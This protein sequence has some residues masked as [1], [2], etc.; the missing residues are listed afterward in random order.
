MPTPNEIIR[1]IELAVNEFN[2]SI[3]KSQ[4]QIFD[5]IQELTKQFTT[6]NDRIKASAENIRLISKIKQKIEKVILTPE[7]KASVKD[8]LGA[9]DTISKLQN[10]YFEENIDKYKQPAILKAIRQESIESTIESLTE[11]GLKEN[12]I[13][14]VRDILR[15]NITSGAPY[16]ELVKQL[17]ENL[18]DT[19]TG[20]GSLVKHTKQITNDALN[21]FARENIN[22]VTS[23]LGLEW[24]SYNGSIIDTSRPFCK[25]M[26]KKKFFNKSEI[27]KLLKGD[28]PEF[29]EFGGKL[30]KDT[31]LPEGMIEGTTEDNFLTNLGGFG[32]RHQ[33]VPVHESIVPDSVKKATSNA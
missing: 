2:K 22:S 11:S 6:K 4:E 1:G 24:F 16:S 28:F 23:D 7:Y 12:L 14:P 29:E 32:C 10:A 18:L 5:E 17:R 13:R 9:F 25:A 19:K 21:T 30:D 15:R 27:P 3:P 20:D 26:H 31:G 33:A 8:Y